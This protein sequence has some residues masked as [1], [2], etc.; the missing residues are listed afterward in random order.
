MISNKNIGALRTL[1]NRLERVDWRLVGSTN[2]ALQGVNVEEKDIDV[3]ILSKDVG[4]VQSALQPYCTK[5]IEYCEN[6][7]F[8]SFFGQFVIGG[9]QVDVMAGGINYKNVSISA[10]DTFVKDP[11]AYEIDGILI[12]CTDLNIE[13]EAYVKLGRLEK[14]ELIKVMID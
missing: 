13:Y 3:R 2:L 7:G 10:D 6:N 8:S 1:S 4:V 9:V 14:A 12:P 11:I 5:Q